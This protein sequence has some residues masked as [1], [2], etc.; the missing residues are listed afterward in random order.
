MADTIRITDTINNVLISIQ[1]SQWDDA[2]PTGPVELITTGRLTREGAGFLLTYRESTL[3]GLEGTVTT[4]KVEGSRVTLSRMGEVCS[5]M[6]FEQGR[7]H[8]SYYETG[9]EP[10]TVGIS[11]RRV[12]SALTDQGGSIEL[13]YQVE[14]DQ[15]HAGRNAIK[16]N[17]S[18]LPS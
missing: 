15:E 18:A 6:I 3:T 13:D 8:L 17:V 11:A 4:L 16:V 10:F 5:H 12:K 1:G 14:I 7:R 2:E 9:G